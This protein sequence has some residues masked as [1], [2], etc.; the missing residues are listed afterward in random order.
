MDVVKVIKVLIKTE[1]RY[2]ISNQ[3]LEVDF[4]NVKNNAVGNV[5]LHYVKAFKN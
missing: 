1:P 2:T 4:G 5:M 3:I